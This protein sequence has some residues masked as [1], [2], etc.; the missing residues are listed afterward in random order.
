MISP[1]FRKAE[2]YRQTTT[3]ATSKQRGRLAVLARR[4]GVEMPRVRSAKEASDAIKRL[5]AHGRLERQPMLE[6]FGR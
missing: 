6:G 3:L 4:S 2:R 5:E 1:A